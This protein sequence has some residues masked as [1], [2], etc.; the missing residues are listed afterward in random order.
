MTFT[1]PASRCL[2]DWI[3]FMDLEKINKFLV[4]GQTVLQYLI[5]S[6]SL[7]QCIKT[8]LAYYCVLETPIIVP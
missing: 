8:S 6:F 4:N 5:V 1:P 2:V 3:Y 7:V